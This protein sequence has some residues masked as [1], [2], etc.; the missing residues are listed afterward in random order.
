MK[1]DSYPPLIYTAHTYLQLTSNQLVNVNAKEEKLSTGP[2]RPSPRGAETSD[3]TA[4]IMTDPAKDI[5][6]AEVH[7]DITQ[8]NEK[9]KSAVTQDTPRECCEECK[10]NEE[11]IKLLKTDLQSK[12]EKI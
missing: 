5:D 10:T 12:Q 8:K 9:K 4:P 11:R 1:T 2:E 6:I 3:V 7:I